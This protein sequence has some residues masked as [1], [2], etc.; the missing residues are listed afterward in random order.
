MS[1]SASPSPLPSSWR[2][3]CQTKLDKWRRREQLEFPAI[4]VREARLTFCSDPALNSS[5]PHG[6]V[7]RTRWW[8]TA[9]LFLRQEH[10]VPSAV[11]LD[12]MWKRKSLTE[13]LW[14]GRWWEGV[15]VQVCSKVEAVTESLG[16]LPSHLAP[17]EVRPGFRVQNK[18]FFHMQLY[19]WNIVA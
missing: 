3:Q 18:N 19:L 7:H 10:G 4:Y 8:M 1:A 16:S 5:H 15:L 9:V 14:V 12:F 17:V 2:P 11:L 13:Q 6:V